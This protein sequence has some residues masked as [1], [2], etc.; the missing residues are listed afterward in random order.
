[1]KVVAVIPARYGSTRFPGKPLALV[2]GKPLL[3]WVWKA[4]NKAVASTKCS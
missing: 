4:Q 1:M 2:A 3:Q